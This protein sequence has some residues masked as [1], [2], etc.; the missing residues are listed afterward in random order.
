MFKLDNFSVIRKEIFDLE[1]LDLLNEKK[2]EI[3]Q[4]SSE[5]K[6]NLI[7]SLI[8]SKA[9]SN[10]KLRNAGVNIK[11]ANQVSNVSNA[12]IIQ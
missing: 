2:S 10:V 5:F 7:E 12:C 8:S 11:I 6:N 1:K 4:I 9:Q 3:K